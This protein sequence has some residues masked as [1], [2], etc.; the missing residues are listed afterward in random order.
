[1]QK[2]AL[3]AA[4]SIGIKSPDKKSETAQTPQAP[5]KVSKPVVSVPP[6]PPAPVTRKEFISEIDRLKGFYRSNPSKNSISF[7]EGVEKLQQRYLPTVTK[8]ESAT[9]KSLRKIYASVDEGVRAQN[10]RKAVIEK[11]QKELDAKVQAAADAKRAAEEKA[12]KLAA[13]QAAA[14]A[15]QKEAQKERDARLKKLQNDLDVMYKKLAEAFLTSIRTN[16]IETLKSVMTEFADF[17]VPNATNTEYGM[18]EEF[19]TFRDQFLPQAFKEFARFQ[20]HLKGVTMSKSI[21]AG[22]RMDIEIVRIDPPPQGVYKAVQVN[23]QK[24]LVKIKLNRR[25]RTDIYDYLNAEAKIKNAAFF[26]EFMEGKF[27]TPMTPAMLPSKNWS[28]FIKVFKRSI[29]SLRIPNSLLR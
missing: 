1:M 8:E 7:L 9:Y 27:R 28:R 13:Q 21:A 2:F 16:N 5:E 23:Q 29:P 14:A 15:R 24:K 20:E 22:S 18:L 26:Y 3:S 6:P 10:Y 17:S 25:L 11:L 4:S 12:R 19:K